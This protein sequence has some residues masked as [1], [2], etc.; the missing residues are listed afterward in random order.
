[1]RGARSEGRL[2]R[3]DSSISA[4][5]QLTAFNSSL[6]SSP[7]HSSQPLSR[8][9]SLIAVSSVLKDKVQKWIWTDPKGVHYGI[10]QGKVDTSA[11]MMLAH[12]VEI[13]TYDNAIEHKEKNG[14]LPRKLWKGIDGARSQQ[15]STVKHLPRPYAARIFEG[16]RCWKKEDEGGEIG[17][18]A[19]EGRLKRSDSKR[20][21]PHIHAS[22]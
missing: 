13:D 21:T 20:N 10:T 18:G 9:A 4:A 19:K 14:E 22:T 2:E 7:H 6:R 5:Q 8:F 3:S 1:M 12:L 15:Y 11:E 16:R 17:R